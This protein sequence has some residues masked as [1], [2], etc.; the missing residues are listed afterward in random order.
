VVI[1]NVVNSLILVS[2]S[3]KMAKDP[4]RNLYNVTL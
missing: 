1:T 3:G 2:S 4:T